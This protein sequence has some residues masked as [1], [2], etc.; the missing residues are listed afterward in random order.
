VKLKVGKLVAEA[1]TVDEIEKLLKT[2]NKHVSTFSK[3]PRKK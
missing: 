1:R 3:K 2:A